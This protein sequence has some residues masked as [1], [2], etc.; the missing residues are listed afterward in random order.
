MICPVCHTQIADGATVCPACHADLSATRVMPKLSGSWCP[1]CGA[2]V[3]AG[4]L[5]CPKCGMSMSSDVAKARQELK[6]RGASSAEESDATSRLPRIESAI[7]S[8]PDPD[9]EFQGSVSSMQRTHVFL[10]AAIASLLIVGGGILFITHPWDPDLNN[11]RATTPADTSQAGYPGELERLSGQD[12]DSATTSAV[13][14]MTPDEQA[15]T[16]LMDAYTQLGELSERADD[17]EAQLDS[18]GIYG[19]DEV[20]A[21]AYDDAKA[22]SIDISNL[23]S[24]ISRIE[25][26]STGTYTADK[27]NISTLAS[28]LRNRIEAITRSWKLSSESSEPLSDKSSILAPMQGNRTTDGS[29]S[30]VNLFLANYESWRPHEL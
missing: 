14:V 29:E 15:Y 2:L 7:P 27:Q 20:R 10:F 26:S 1:S 30:Y 24:A 3:P 28:W 18:D 12:K 8:E 23:A 17:L 6:D 19:S 21:S 13:S 25:T 4:A 9:S 16:D 22:L 5:T 11:T